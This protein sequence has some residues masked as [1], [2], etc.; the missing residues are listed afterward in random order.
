MHVTIRRNRWY[1]VEDE[2]RQSSKL[3]ASVT[4]LFSPLHDRR[5][6]ASNTCEI[7]H[8]DNGEQWRMIVVASHEST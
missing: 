2:D 5:R 8:I 7:A 3:T 1:V 6:E 4:R